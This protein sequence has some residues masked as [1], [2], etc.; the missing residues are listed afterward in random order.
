VELTQ[1]HATSL[2]LLIDPAAVFL[3]VASLH[4]SSAAFFPFIFRDNA[5]V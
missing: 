2:E 3:E 4:E 5:T 1:G